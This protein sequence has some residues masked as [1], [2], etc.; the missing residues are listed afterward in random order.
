M[1]ITLAVADGSRP[2]G[3]LTPV[4]YVD[5]WRQAAEDGTVGLF[6]REEKEAFLDSVVRRPMPLAATTVAGGPLDDFRPAR[7]AEV[8]F[9]GLDTAV[10]FTKSDFKTQL[11]DLVIDFC[12]RDC[13]FRVKSFLNDHPE[14]QYKGFFQ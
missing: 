9:I 5:V 12:V 2:A 7:C 14:R 13:V 6:T 11:N 8:K 1:A 10:T 3:R 4:T